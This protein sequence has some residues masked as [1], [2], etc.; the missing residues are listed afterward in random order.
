VDHDLSLTQARFRIEFTVTKLLCL[1]RFLTYRSAPNLRQVRK[2]ICD[3]QSMDNLSQLY[4]GW[5]AWL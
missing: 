1:G 5:S 2:L 4:R 3:A